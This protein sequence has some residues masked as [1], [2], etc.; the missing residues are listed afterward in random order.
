MQALPRAFGRFDQAV[1]AKAIV[2][3]IAI[4]SMSS[5]ISVS[6]ISISMLGSPQEKMC[7]VRAFGG[8]EARAMLNHSTIF[9]TSFLLQHGS[10]RQQIFQRLGASRNSFHHC[11][12][13]Q[14]PLSDFVVEWRVALC[15]PWVCRHCTSTL[16]QR[17]P[18]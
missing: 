9:P 10:F 4:A 17:R 15:N 18:Q 11:L 12:S 2:I 7:A 16:S 1:E 13:L 5:I 6:V 3:G 14:D 8:E